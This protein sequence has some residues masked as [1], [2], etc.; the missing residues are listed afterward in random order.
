MSL[1]CNSNTG[2]VPMSVFNVIDSDNDRVVFF[3]KV[4]YE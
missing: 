1:A 2:G 3:L 4:L